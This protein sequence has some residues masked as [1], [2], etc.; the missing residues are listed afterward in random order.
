MPGL[1]AARQLQEA[2]SMSNSINCAGSRKESEARR[3]EVDVERRR[4]HPGEPRQ[5]IVADRPAPGHDRRGA[6]GLCG[7][8]EARR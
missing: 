6:H 2:P 7:G 4:A 5:V 8:R 3:H 1:C